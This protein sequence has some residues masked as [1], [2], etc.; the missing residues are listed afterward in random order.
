MSYNYLTLYYY[1]AALPNSVLL[2]SIDYSCMTDNYQI[3][4][5]LSIYFYTVLVERSLFQ[6]VYPFLCFD[7]L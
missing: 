7:K 1:I 3:C 4:M 6:V 2:Y 5:C